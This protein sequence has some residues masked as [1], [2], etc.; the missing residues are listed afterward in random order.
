M[1]STTHITLPHYH[2]HNHISYSSTLRHALPHS[3]IAHQEMTAV[4]TRT[5]IDRMIGCFVFVILGTYTRSVTLCD[6]HE[7]SYILYLVYSVVM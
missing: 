4:D 6:I 7:G 1:D 3:Y 2:M 5:R